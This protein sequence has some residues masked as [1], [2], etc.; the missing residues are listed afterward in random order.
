MKV[1]EHKLRERN[2]EK[3]QKRL[4]IAIVLNILIVLL[5]VIYGFI[6]NS[7]SLL[8]DALHNLQ[9]VVALIIAVIAVI[10]TSKLPTKDMTYGFIRSEALAGFVNSLALMI[11]LFVIILFAIKRLISPEVVEGLYV[12]V[13]GL[14]GFVINLVSAKIIHIHHHEEENH[15]HEDLNIKSAYLHLLSDAGISLAVFLGGLAIYFYKIYWID[16]LLSLIFSIYILKETFPVLRIV[17]TFLWKLF[18]NI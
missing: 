8:A 3:P 9:D 10:F 5:Q 1:I 7:I 2:L 14:L 15:N 6:S 13:F 11:T 4:Y 17:I 18:Q 16:P 12:A